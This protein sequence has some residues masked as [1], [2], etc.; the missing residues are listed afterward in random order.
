MPLKK[1]SKVSKNAKKEI[2]TNTHTI[3]LQWCACYN[4]YF[5]Q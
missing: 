5:L 3:G 1:V 2:Q 4:L